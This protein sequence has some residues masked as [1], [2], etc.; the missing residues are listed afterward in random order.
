M[1][2]YTMKMQMVNENKI[3]FLMNVND[4]LLDDYA[5]IIISAIAVV[6]ADAYVRERD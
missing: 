5:S 4:N 2:V 6:V 3:Q 1:Y